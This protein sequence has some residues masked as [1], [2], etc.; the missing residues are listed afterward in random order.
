MNCEIRCGPERAG[1]EER[2]SSATGDAEQERRPRADHEQE[3][4]DARLRERVELER[5]CAIGNLVALPVDEV[6]A[7]PAVR[8]D[9]D[10]RVALELVP[11]DAQKS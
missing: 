8:P 1:R 6:R 4:D 2:A 10:E 3:A 11:G 5:V 9:A 7:S